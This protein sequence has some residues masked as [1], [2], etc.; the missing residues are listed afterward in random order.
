MVLTAH[1]MAPLGLAKALSSWLLTSSAPVASGNAGVVGAVVAGVAI[2]DVEV[3]VIGLAEGIPAV[4]AGA[5]GL[6]PA[7]RVNNP[8]IRNIRS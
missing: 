5:A 4:V 8:R 3:D 6:Q 1:Q 7:V 2:G